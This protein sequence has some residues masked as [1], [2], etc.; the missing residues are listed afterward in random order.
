MDSKILLGAMMFAMNVGTRHVIEELTPLQHR[1]MSTTVAKRFV[2]FAIFY[3]AVRDVICALVLTGVSS[4]ALATLLNE[5]SK[6]YLFD[7]DLLNE[8]Y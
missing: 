4:L 7:F 8:P 2:L 1:A 3:M 6:Y 5:S